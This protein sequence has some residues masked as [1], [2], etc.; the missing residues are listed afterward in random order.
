MNVIG[1]LPTTN[2]FLSAKEYSLDDD[3]FDHPI[4]M[5]GGVCVMITGGRPVFEQ[6]ALAIKPKQKRSPRDVACCKRGVSVVDIDVFIVYIL[7]ALL[8][9]RRCL[10]PMAYVFA[11]VSTKQ[12]SGTIYAVI[13]GARAI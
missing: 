7:Q 8:G 5:H 9:A 2:S 4:V 13:M 3:H 10:P 11:Y 12:G 1:L 6:R